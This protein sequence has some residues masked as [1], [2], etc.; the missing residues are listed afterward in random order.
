MPTL[1][2]T[3][4][5]T[6]G[7]AANIPDEGQIGIRGSDY[8]RLTKL[9]VILESK[10]DN[11]PKLDSD[12]NDLTP[13]EKKLFRRRYRALRPELVNE[14]GT[15]VYLLGKNIKDDADWSFLR[16]VAAEPPCLSLADCSQ[17]GTGPS[18]LGDEVTLAYPSLVALK[19]AQKIL[20]K[21]PGS[22]PARGVVAAG[23]NSKTPAV[24]RLAAKI[25]QPSSAK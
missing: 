9:E 14:R 3:P 20:E 19:Q 4:L 22:F 21:E 12:F 15:I 5:S 10:N 6:I 11:D 23:L 24:E 16:E 18:G 7:P 13:G 17:R 2:V 25:A 1:F 8:D